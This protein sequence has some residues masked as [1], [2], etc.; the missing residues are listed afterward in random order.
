MNISLLFKS[1]QK[2]GITKRIILTLFLMS[3][4]STLFEL[5][6][7]SIFLPIFDLLQGENAT[8]LN[9][10]DNR[11]IARLTSILRD[12]GIDL[13]LGSLL[14]LVFLLFGVSRFVIFYATKFNS[15]ITNTH[16][17]LLRDKLFEA[18][19]FSNSDYHDKNPIGDLTN[20]VSTEAKN[21]ITG[22]MRPV[23]F[24][25]S[26]ISIIGSII[27]LF[28][29][30]YKMTSIAIIMIIFS[31]AI[32]I[33]WVKETANV[34]RRITKSNKWASS[35]IV[36]RIRS[37]RL[38]RLAGTEQAEFDLF[39]VLTNNQSSNTF[40]IQI[41]KAK[42]ALVIEPLLIGFSLLMLYIGYVYFEMSFSVIGIYLLVVMR[43]TPMVKMLM[44]EMHAMN[45]ALGPIELV[46]LK[47]KQMT[48]D[49][50]IDQ[51]QLTL[52]SFNKGLVFNNV[53][54]KYKDSR[55]FALKNVTL[56]IMPNSMTAIVGPSGSGKSTLVDMIPRLRSSSIGEITLNN[57][58]INK[59]SLKSLRGFI[60]YLTQD[61]QIFDGSIIDHIRYGKKCAT[62]KE[63][64]HVVHL[65]GLSSFIKTLPDGYT[66]LLGEGAVRLSGGQ[67]QR[68]DLARA[69][70]KNA[71]ILILDE[72]TSSLDAKS[73][74][75]FFKS[76]AKIQSVT[77][78]AI[79][80]VV[81]KLK[82]I[83]NADQIIVLNNGELECIGSHDQ[84]IK[85]PNWYSETLKSHGE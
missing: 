55:D 17:K 24:S 50:E 52:T 44:S 43:L 36:D 9:S 8:S 4:M 3:A 34:S 66:T 31:M 19:M 25:V 28:L 46:N 49:K 47:L 83:K 60:S 48:N 29:L 2:F 72:P 1:A 41:L 77:G 26:L 38:V 11:F 10:G 69:L 5:I 21:A 6:S 15:K 7:V 80:V 76:I 12:I 53:S 23:N 33:G 65:S 70:L 58:D 85:Y 32:P 57:I 79:V 16:I 39:G 74:S 61:A 62:M 18:Y 42:T 54:Y 14:M 20:T 35:F 45:N 40:K 73:E 51:G 84:L 67:R 59:Y 30:S 64:E 75:D 82:L 71:P 13:N 68:L 63:V 78:V 27:L 56:K 22:A 81:H 37:A